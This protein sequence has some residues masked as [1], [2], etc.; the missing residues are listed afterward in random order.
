MSYLIEISIPTL[1]HDNYPLAATRWQLLVGSYSLAATRWQLL[2][3]SYSLAA[4][5]SID[6]AA[7]KT[8]GNASTD[9]APPGGS[10]LP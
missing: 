8:D 1:A 6:I 3:G 4:S 9:L 10:I 7:V 5:S 2:V